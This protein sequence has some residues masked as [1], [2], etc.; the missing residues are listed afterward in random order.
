MTSAIAPPSRANLVE[1][2]PLVRR[3]AALDPATLVRL[4]LESRTVTA[5]VRLPFGVLAGRSVPLDH[6]PTGVDSTYAAGELLAWIDDPAG[7]APSTRDA[8][9]R[10]GLPPGS[11]WR[12]VDTVPD[13][14]VRSLVRA[15]AQTLAQAAEREGV[16]GAQP[17]AEVADALLNSVVLTVTDGTVQVEINLRMASALTRMGFLPPKSGATVDVAG[18]WKRIA[19]RFGSIYAERPGVGLQLA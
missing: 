11:N 5:F 1:L 16:P 6:S 2:E 7:V 3:A 4:R 12:K 8:D 19:G 9:W 10:D 15:G 18:R 17:R 14:V 13:D